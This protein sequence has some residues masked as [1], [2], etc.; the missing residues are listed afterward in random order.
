M[1]KVMAKVFGY[2]EFDADGV[3]TLCTYDNEYSAMN[4]D[5]GGGTAMWVYGQGNSRNIVNHV[6]ENRWDWNGTKLR[7]TG[8]TIYI[9]SDLK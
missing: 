4:M 6:S 8:N 7:A 3:R 2:P 9:R 1:I 5:G